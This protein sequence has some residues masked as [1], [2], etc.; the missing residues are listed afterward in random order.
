MNPFEPDF[1]SSS[2]PIWYD[3]LEERSNEIRKLVSHHFPSLDKLE[4]KVKQVGGIELNSN[5]Y[6]IENTQ[7]KF[8][9]KK[10]GISLNLNDINGICEL[11]FSLNKRNLPVSKLIP[12]FNQSLV[13]SYNNQY[14]SL[15]E[16]DN[17]DFYSGTVQE[18]KSVAQAIGMLFSNLSKIE[19]NLVSLKKP[20]ICSPNDYQL[21]KNFF[22][23]PEAVYNKINDSEVELLK[24]NKNLL[25][26][27]VELIFNSNINSGIF[28]FS[29]FDLHPHNILVKQGEVSSFLDLDSIRLMESGYALGFASLKLCRQGVV[30]TG[31]KPKDVANIWLKNL[32]EFLPDNKEFFPL[33]GDLAIAEVLRRIAIILRLNIVNGNTQWNAFFPVQLNHLKEA[34]LLFNN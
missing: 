13:I 9:L 12:A 3:C 10:W 20:D 29:H 5:N 22:Y 19:D 34:R 11:T 30:K 31:L 15:F 26:K 7:G 23:N 28:Q 24:S 33:I 2:K 4:N 17:S 16:F 18:L 27:E 21:F 25:Q 32:A 14:W 8:L 1:F 6:C